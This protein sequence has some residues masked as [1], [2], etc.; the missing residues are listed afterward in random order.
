MAANI[1]QRYKPAALTVQVAQAEGRVLQRR[2]LVGVRA[3][4]LGQSI[5]R[6]LTSPAM[7]LWAGGLGFAAGHF[8]QR[9]ASTPSNIERPRGSYNELF[10]RALKLIAFARTLSRAF[11]SA[12]N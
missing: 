5:R 2:R 11:P 12:A 7:L 1:R 4:M 3:S 9:E 6:Q 8:T 10:A